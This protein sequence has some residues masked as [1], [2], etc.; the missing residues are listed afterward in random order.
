MLIDR[1]VLEL[2]EIL[3]MI[4]NV[5]SLDEKVDEALEVLNDK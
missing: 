5:S 2:D 3:D 4:L 1:E